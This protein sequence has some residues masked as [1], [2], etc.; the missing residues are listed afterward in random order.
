VI[1]DPEAYPLNLSIWTGKVPEKEKAIEVPPR[2]GPA[3]E[4]KPE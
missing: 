3:G 1:F 4:K 2:K